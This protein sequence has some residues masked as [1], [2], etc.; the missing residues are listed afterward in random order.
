MGMDYAT[1]EPF[2]IAE[3][4][5]TMERFKNFRGSL[6]F[7]FSQFVPVSM[8]YLETLSTDPMKF[9]IHLNPKHRGL[10]GGWLRP[11]KPE[12]DVMDVL[13]DYMETPLFRDMN[14]PEVSALFIEMYFRLEDV[15]SRGR[16]RG[17]HE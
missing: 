12:E 8:A 17:K 10:V 15:V 5:E 11:P 6:T 16:R 9:L 14:E 1:S 2:T 4:V 7:N 3:L 13:E